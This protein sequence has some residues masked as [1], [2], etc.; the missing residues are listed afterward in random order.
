MATDHRV[1]P[2]ER[3]DL[4]DV[5]NRAGEPNA[6][7]FQLPEFPSQKA[8][9]SSFHSTWAAIEENLDLSL[10][11]EEA[12][13]LF[14]DFTLYD[15]PDGT[16]TTLTV[17]PDVDVGMDAALFCLAMVH[18]LKHLGARQCVIMTHTAYNR[19]RGREGL[20]RILRLLADGVKP[21]SEYA[22]KER[23]GIDLV[24]L[25]EDYEL[26]NYLLG[27]LPRVNGNAFRAHFLVDYAEEGVG[28]D[29]L[30]AQYEALPEVD[31][32]VRHT[33]LNLSG[34]GWIP[35]K[36]LKATFLYSQNGSLFSNWTFD[37]LVALSTLSLVA[38]LVHTGEGL[39]KMY[40]D[41]DEVK[42]RYQLRELRLFN[43][44][45]Q[46]RPDPKKLFVFGAPQGLYQF[47]Y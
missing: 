47:Y 36:L 11:S 30:R 6:S 14:A 35:S 7:A 24:G 12:L 3:E 39:V 17:R 44:R 43:E 37:E 13:R 34:G 1:V 4:S 19:A 27:H 15:I 16:R 41:I 42:A 10:T 21:V 26:R 18:T 25:S 45:V 2:R 20:G 8:I 28:D 23:I 5:A 33:K 46:L 31:V 32:C 22:R 40:G 38:K 29:A 9:R